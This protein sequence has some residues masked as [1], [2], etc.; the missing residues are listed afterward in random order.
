[1]IVVN[2]MAGIALN[3][4]NLFPNHGDNRMVHYCAAAG[5]LRFNN[6]S[7]R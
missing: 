7:G 2:A 1:M 5:T 3:A 6:A 4:H